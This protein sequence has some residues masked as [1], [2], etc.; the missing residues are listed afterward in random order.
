MTIKGSSLV[1]TLKSEEARLSSA[2]DTTRARQDDLQRSQTQTQSAAMNAWEAL[3]ASSV[4]AASEGSEMRAALSSWAKAQSTQRS[5]AEQALRRAEEDLDKTTA[6][7]V[8]ADEAARTAERAFSDHASAARVSWEQTEDA[9]ALTTAL[10]AAR[11][12][13]ARCDEEHLF[14]DELLNTAKSQLHKH[15]PWH[16]EL[17]AQAP[18]GLAKLIG[19]F[20]RQEPNEVIVKRLAATATAAK[21][22][23][24]AARS[25][26]SVCAAAL[27]AAETN[28]IM[29][30]H[31][32]Q[33]HAAWQ[34]AE[35]NS[36]TADQNRLAAQNAA[37]EARTCVQDIVRNQTPQ[38]ATGVS[39]GEHAVVDALLKQWSDRAIAS[40][41]SQS[42]ATEDDQ[43]Y[44]TWARLQA[45]LARLDNE[46]VRARAETTAAHGQWEQARRARQHASSQGWDSDR[47][48]FDVDMNDVL[49]SGRIVD[50]LTRAARYRAPPPPRPPS[51]PSG[52]GS[53]GGG[54]FSSR[55]SFG[56]GGF[57]T[58]SGF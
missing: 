57:S 25:R 21:E 4:Q 26:F 51:S 47:Y 38:N 30:G 41:V 8:S 55:G 16:E 40:A 13:C 43:A 53:I 37:E 3:V 14:W 35:T 58:K 18:S 6:I 50:Q 22:E 44:A 52:G 7:A 33:K 27:E 9:D 17:Q 42:P 1:R 36:T 34:S 10:G 5:A 54:G 49:R 12:E 2:H 32:A 20:L 31:G 15:W 23:A 28:A 39:P 24:Y 19:P 29:A 48:D 11:A 45:T 56:G 46:L